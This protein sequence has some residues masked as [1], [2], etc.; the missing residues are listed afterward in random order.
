[1]GDGSVSL[2]LTQDTE[3]TLEMTGVCVFDFL[4]SLKKI[5]IRSGK[6]AMDHG[7]VIGI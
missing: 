2:E 1:M 6:P 3:G 5:Y 4:L 7:D